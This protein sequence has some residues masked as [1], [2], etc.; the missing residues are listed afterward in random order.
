M[1][2]GTVPEQSELDQA[3]DKYLRHAK[4]RGL[5]PASLTS[6]QRHID[7]FTEFL[8]KRTRR[9]VED[10]RP[11]DLTAFERHL[12]KHEFAAVT[13]SQSRSIVGK[14]LRYLAHQGDVDTTVFPASTGRRRKWSQEKIVAK[15]KNLH[16]EGVSIS[17]PGL[18]QAGYGSLTNAACRYFGSLTAARAA[19]GLDGVR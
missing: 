11:S 3:R 1:Y 16:R 14:W 8:R 2:G 13:C 19:A 9:R 12:S 6:Y 7:R 18:R 15:L 10:I 4:R 5:S 17:Y